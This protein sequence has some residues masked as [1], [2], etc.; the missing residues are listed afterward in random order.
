[1]VQQRCPMEPAVRFVLLCLP[2][3]DNAEKAKAAGADFV[4]M[5]ELAEEVKGG[6]MD[7]DVV[8]SQPGCNESCWPARISIRAPWFDAQP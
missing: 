5:E 3:G 7:F 8:S 6:M 1:M 4:G 2:P